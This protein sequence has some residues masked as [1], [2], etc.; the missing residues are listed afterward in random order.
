MAT[1]LALA[2]HA[3]V[4][5]VRRGEVYLQP[6]FVLRLLPPIAQGFEAS[7]ARSLGRSSGAVAPAYA[8]AFATVRP[9]DTVAQLGRRALAAFADGELPKLV[10][11]LHAASYRGLCD[12]AR[13]RADVYELGEHLAAVLVEPPSRRPFAP[14]PEPDAALV[15][16]VRQGFDR[17]V[18]PF[19]TPVAGAS[20]H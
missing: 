18:A 14:R 3:V 13:F 2:I 5:E 6:G 17:G 10:L 15:R 11:E 20:L 8:R 4:D 19:A 7:L 12:P 1:G 16:A 9:E